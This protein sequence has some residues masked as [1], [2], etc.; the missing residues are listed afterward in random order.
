M[1]VKLNSTA[2]LCRISIATVAILI[3]LSSNA[4]KMRP[5]D[6]LIN[7]SDPGWPLVQKWISSAKNK[8]EVL[9]R[10]TAKAKDALYKT[11]V[12]TRSPMGAI[13]YSTG[14]ILIDDGWIRVLGSGSDRL[15]RS[16]P[17]WNKGKTMA[18]YGG[19]SPFYLVADDAIGGFFAING[20]GLGNDPGKVYY[21]APDNLEWSD[22]DLSYSEFL[23]FCFSG[24]LEKYYSGR[25]W[26]NW[27]KEVASL[28]GDKTYNF[29]PPLWTKEGKD[30]EKVSR[31]A[32]SAEEQ[33]SFTL[34]TRKQLGIK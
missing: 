21:L 32:V 5:I 4:Q 18:D 34:D 27:R 19:H 1:P 25:R 2:L 16:L 14:G 20:G 23:Q 12:T 28:A 3:S 10:D 22:M 7:T 8:V 24:D 26:K 17:E 15:P 13:V 6:E 33:Y 31:K 11:Q 30:I 9:P 29:Y